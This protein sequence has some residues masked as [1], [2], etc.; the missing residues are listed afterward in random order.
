MP[1]FLELV[2]AG[3][4][5]RCIYTDLIG[6]RGNIVAQK[7]IF[8]CL[9]KEAKLRYWQPLESGVVAWLGRRSIIGWGRDFRA[10]KL[11]PFALL[12]EVVRLSVTIPDDSGKPTAERWDGARE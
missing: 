1:S 10:W 4:S 7:N 8:R 12:L 2:S 11:W 3:V 6:I 5:P 9:R